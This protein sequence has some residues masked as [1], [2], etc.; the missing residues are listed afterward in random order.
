MRCW[1]STS[2]PCGTKP[3]AHELLSQREHQV[4]ILIAAG[5]SL[6]EIAAQ[7]SLSLNTVSTYRTRTMEK[8]DTHNDVETA[9]YAVRHH[10][11]S[12]AS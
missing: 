4:F 7:L 5:K 3:G 11:L 1:A 8:I 12:M 2:L 10:L 6:T 9:L